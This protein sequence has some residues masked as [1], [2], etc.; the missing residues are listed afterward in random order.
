MKKTLKRLIRNLV[1]IGI[2]LQ[3]ATDKNKVAELIESLYPF[4]TQ[5]E[6]IRLGSKAD[7]GYLVPNNLDGIEACFSPGVSLVS[8]F[9]LDCLKNKMKVFMADKSVD[10]PNLNI[11]EKEYNFIKKFVG[12]TNNHD[13]ITMDDWVNSSSLSDSSDLLLQMDIEGA[14]YN[15]F[16]NMSDS[17]I[18]RF[19]IMVIEFHH[20]EQLWNP[21]FFDYTQLVFKKILQTHI[22]IHIHP[23]NCCGIDS[24]NGINIPRVAEFTFMRKDCAKSIY[25]ASSFPHALDHDNTKNKSISLPKNWYK[26]P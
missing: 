16:I 18:K 22:C 26:S 14:E 10:K 4:Q 17:L 21:I 15:S 7:G 2:V 11:P 24:Q 25:F 5:F 13:F 19:K 20:L 6:L 9:E 3:R 1:K 23:N 12:C 8:E